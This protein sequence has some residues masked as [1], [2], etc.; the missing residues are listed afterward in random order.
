MKIKMLKLFTDL[1]SIYIKYISILPEDSLSIKQTKYFIRYNILQM[2]YIIL[3]YNLELNLDTKF[4]I[5]IFGYIIFYDV[6]EKNKIL[7]PLYF[8]LILFLTSDFVLLEVRNNYVSVRQREWS[9]DKSFNFSRRA[10]NKWLLC[11]FK[12]GYECIIRWPEVRSDG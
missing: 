4:I 2:A 1:L 11:I 9:Y 8:I 12:R 5:L 6:F 3:S 7:T 10:S